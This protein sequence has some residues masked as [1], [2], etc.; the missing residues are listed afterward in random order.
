MCKA[1]DGTNLLVACVSHSSN[2]R[3]RML[4]ERSAD[5]FLKIT[6]QIVKFKQRQ[7]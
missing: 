1:F 5:V 3:A 4:E 2:L 6:Y 7:L